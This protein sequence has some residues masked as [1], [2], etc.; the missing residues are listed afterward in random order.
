MPGLPAALPLLGWAAAAAGLGA[1]VF[2]LGQPLRA[3]RVFLGLRRSWLSREAVLL[4]AWFPLATLLAA[5]SHLPAGLVPAPVLAALPAA[6]LALGVIALFCS[7]MIYVDTHRALWRFSQTSGR[8]YGGG[9]VLGAASAFAVAPH[10][11]AAALLALG[12]I[13][14]L[15]LETVC[16]RALDE[17]DALGATVPV[18]TTPAFKTARLLTGPLRPVLAFRYVSAVSLLLLPS[19]LLAYAPGSALSWAVLG[20]AFASELAERLLYFRAVAAP[21]MPGVLTP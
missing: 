16:L 17:E 12:L 15:A 1:G 20:L 3:W 7:V 4:G 21:K 11:V 13:A 2:H 19:V 8:F 9:L 18:E 5:S 6:T 10:G 14:K